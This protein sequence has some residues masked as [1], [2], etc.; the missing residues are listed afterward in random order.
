MPVLWI[1]SAN[2]HFWNAQYVVRKNAL[3]ITYT[4][5]FIVNF[6]ESHV[7]IFLKRMLLNRKFLMLQISLNIYHWFQQIRLVYI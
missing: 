4:H 6:K 1:H 7:K 2:Y 5:K 3:N